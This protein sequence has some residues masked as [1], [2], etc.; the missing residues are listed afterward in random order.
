MRLAHPAEVWKLQEPP[1]AKTDVTSKLLSKPG[2]WFL[3]REEEIPEVSPGLEVRP[4]RGV[5]A[6]YVKKAPA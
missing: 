6:R 1:A 5:F 3:L 4:I 2:V